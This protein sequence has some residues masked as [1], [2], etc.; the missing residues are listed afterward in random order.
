MT[1]V[2][3]R[4]L[5]CLALIQAYA[6]SKLLKMKGFRTATEKS[7]ST[8]SEAGELQPTPTPVEFAKHLKSLTRNS[9][10]VRRLDTVI[11]FL[12][13]TAGKDKKTVCLEDVLSQISTLSDLRILRIDLR[14]FI[15]N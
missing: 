14:F 8:Q 9:D 10:I 15:P 2:Q 4:F 6:I 11:H 13:R 7:E 5:T 1:D 12:E 3:S